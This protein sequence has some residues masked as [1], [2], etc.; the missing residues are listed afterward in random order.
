MYNRE[1]TG[2]TYSILQA[3]TYTAA[4]YSITADGYDPGGRS[5]YDTLRELYKYVAKQDKYHLITT[6]GD[7]NSCGDRWTRSAA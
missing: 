4:L 6:G 2:Y 5:F 7:S 3:L 1:E